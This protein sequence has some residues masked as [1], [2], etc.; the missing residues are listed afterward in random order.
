MLRSKKFLKLIVLLDAGLV[1]LILAFWL[2]RGSVWASWDFQVLDRFHEHAIQEG[3]GPEASPRLVYLLITDDAYAE[4]D[5]NALDRGYLSRVNRILSMLRPEAVAFDIIFAR[6]G[7]PATDKKF[8]RSIAR[9]RTAYLPIAFRLADSSKP[10]DWL[11]GSVYAQLNSKITASLPETGEAQPFYGDQPVLQNDLFA[12]KARGTGHI[13]AENDSDGVYRHFPL[14][15]KLGDRYFPSLPLQMFLDFAG[16]PFE[17]VQ[18]EWGRALTI[19]AV[20]GGRLDDARVIPIDERG[21]VYVPYV[22]TW[23]HDFPKVAVTRL[24]ELFADEDM[25]GNLSEFFGGRFVMLGD[26][27]HGISDIGQTPLEENVPL[28]AVHASVLNGLLENRFYDRWTDGQ[29]FACLGALAVLLG[30]AA[31]FRQL[32]I[33]YLVGFGGLAGL[34]ALA[35]WQFTHDSLF[36]VT[37]ATAAY[38]VVFV[39]LVVGLQVSLSRHG[40]FIRTAFSRYV[41]VQVVEQLLE[42]PDLL[43]LGGE[44]REATVLFSDL[45]GF[46]T[47]SETMP[48][49]H[50]AKLLNEYLTEMT[51][52]IIENGGIIDKYLG[53]GIMAEFGIPLDTPSHA[54]HAVRAAL[55]MQ[56]ALRTM[57]TGWEKQGRVQVKCRIGIHTGTLIAGNLG[58]DQ[59]FD[60]TV[61]GD[62]V[63]LAA[64]LEG[65]NKLYHTEVIISEKTRSLLTPEVF[66]VRPLDIIKV[67]GKSEPVRIYEVYGLEV[68]PMTEMDADYYRLYEEGFRAYLNREFA[69]AAGLFN[70]SLQIR[71]G[72]APSLNML[73]C[74]NRL[75]PEDLPK[76]WDGS[77]ALDFK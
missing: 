12:A 10:F 36:P 60:Y 70:Q 41:P 21:Q 71:P 54:D 75:N 32:W 45:E 14:L 29:V 69:T 63:N 16:V 35:W 13:N 18:V 25:Q 27:S 6:E 23:E 17:H 74:M 44:E 67:K 43:R 40:A 28:I 57:N 26:V 33:Y 51:R 64:R 34:G 52:I 3:K 38:L 9:L 50:L 15:I 24:R 59:V 37:S 73:H 8:A 19:P 39:G 65:V 66:R 49:P 46:T 11:P 1:L 4:F 47:V 58:S 62:S 2:L 76:D 42:N 68:K 56:T 72:D 31:C 5:K 22:N 53:D 61:I 7:D 20:E 55:A 30:G 48:P 77:T